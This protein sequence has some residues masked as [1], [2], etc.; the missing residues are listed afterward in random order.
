MTDTAA[1]RLPGHQQQ[2]ASGRA[3]RTRQ[4][5]TLADPAGDEGDRL[6]RLVAIGTT[7]VRVHLARVTYWADQGDAE[8][9]YGALVDLFVS[10]RGA[11]GEV[12]NR[13][14]YWARDVLTDDRYRALA[15]LVNDD[16]D[17]TAPLP[18]TVRAVRALGVTGELR[19]VI[20]EPLAP[21]PDPP[22]LVAGPTLA[23]ER[24][25]AAPPAPR[26]SAAA[27]DALPDGWFDPSRTVIAA[28]RRYAGFNTAFTLTGAYGR[29]E[30]K[31]A[32][33]WF[34]FTPNAAE[35]LATSEFTDLIEIRHVEPHQVNRR[36]ARTLDVAIWDL[37]TMVSA[38]RLP[39]GMPT[40]VPL[41]LRR[42]PDLS[43]LARVDGDAQLSALL[44]RR[45]TRVSDL[46]ATPAAR[47]FL[48]AAWVGGLLAET[49]PVTTRTSERRATKSGLLG[50]VRGR[51]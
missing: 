43:G 26:R 13:A 7:D 39:V 28:L 34:D 12:R 25:L 45:P 6:D 10:V 35:A 20:D 22:A 49:D 33:V 15:R 14:L 51:A 38:G 17:R 36:G 41:R 27:G 30:V 32:A 50:R 11:A 9:T 42:Q 19:L 1:N 24:P 4:H 21:V 2:P 48:A 44:V 8:G 31:A 5:L 18:P 37:T 46:P 3:S 23:A 16:L 47:T 40:D 29:I